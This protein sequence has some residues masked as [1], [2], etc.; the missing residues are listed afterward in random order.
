MAEETKNIVKHIVFWDLCNFGGCALR[1]ISWSF[2]DDLG[3]IWGSKIKPK[4]IKYQ[5]KKWLE[6]RCKLGWMYDRSWID[7]WSI[8][9]S[10]WGGSWGQVGTKI[11]KNWVPRRHQNII[12][13][14]ETQE[15][16]G[17]RNKTAPWPY[18]PPGGGAR[19]V[20]GWITRES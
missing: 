11:E 4:S 16:A 12:K 15:A 14:Q 10:I 20:I 1:L 13:K 9:A 19:R 3:W 7:F 17:T 6:I 18:K 8:L 5:S 2:W